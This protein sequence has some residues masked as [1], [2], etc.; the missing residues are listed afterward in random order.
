MK[1]LLLENIHP[2]AVAI[3]EAA[4]LEVET[5][6]GALGTDDL[7]AALDGVSLLGI[8]SNT[9]VTAE[10]LAAAPDSLL[11]IG[12][13]CI[14]TNQIDLDA[15]AARG[16]AVFNAPF[17]N[18]R[19][20]VEL[21]MAEIIVLARHLTDRST[22]MHQGKWVKSATGSHEVR[23]KTIGIVGYGNIGSQLSVLAESYGMRVIYFDI[24]DKLALG[25]AKRCLTLD[26]LVEAADVVTI[27]VDGRASNSGLFDESVI[28]K[29]KDRAF[30]MN[31]SRGHVVDLGS[32]ARHLRSGHL[33][34]AS[35]DVFPSEPKSAGDP[36]VH[37]L[38]G[39]D[40]V[41]LTPHVGGST[42]EA[43][44]DIGHYVAGKLF[45]FVS[46]GSTVMSVNLPNVQGPERTGGH[47]VLHFH[48]NVPGVL[49]KLNAVLA[50]HSANVAFQA[51]STRGE[52]GY[53]I[54]DV[55]AADRGLTEEL[56][57][58]SEA[59]RVR[60]IRD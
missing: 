4:G 22:Q 19:S 45:E 52:Y 44:V 42:Q 24:A 34:G 27:H 20:V 11:A 16:I 50:D 56:S 13:F 12:A 37:E 3:L 36:F 28:A 55:S 14:G 8:R 47:R 21:V 43:Q 33:A 32:L 31:L 6:A 9:K 53:V 29:M 26:E 46:T 38:Q 25:N 18:T 1:A 7:I 60:V 39:I 35:I 10:V 49:A 48:H 59:I 54:T 30:L 23:G 51:L 17:S 5:R 40:N 2:D 15:A 58:M 57:A 41:I